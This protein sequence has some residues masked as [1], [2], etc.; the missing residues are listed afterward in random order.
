VKP[1]GRPRWERLAEARSWPLAT[2]P[3]LASGHA[4]GEYTMEVRVSPSAVE[5]YR[6]LTAGKQWVPGTSLVAFHLRRQ[7][8]AAASIYAMTKLPDGRWEYVVAAPDGTLEA[9]GALPLCTRCHA[10]APADSLFGAPRTATE[11]ST[12]IPRSLGNDHALSSARSS[13]DQPPKTRR[14]AVRPHAAGHLK[15]SQEAGIRRERS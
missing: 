9:R 8:G 5:D 4:G 11:S 12:A 15:A 13:A 1:A 6:A 10:D 7:D 2:P 3:F 14:P